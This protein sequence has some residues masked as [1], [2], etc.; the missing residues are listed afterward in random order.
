MLA[1]EEGGLLLLHTFT[2][3]LTQNDHE[4]NSDPKITLHAKQFFQ[5]AGC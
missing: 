3:S 5:G 1:T 2:Y 4:A